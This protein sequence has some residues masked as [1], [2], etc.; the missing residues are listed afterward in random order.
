MEKRFNMR[1][2]DLL[3]SGEGE[4]RWLTSRYYD[5]LE[6]RRGHH[7]A[8]KEA[9][10]LTHIL[11]K[12]EERIRTKSWSAS[13][14]GECIRKQQ[15]VYL[16][17]PKMRLDTKSLNIFSNGDYV[18]MRHQVAGLSRGYLKDVEVPV[19]ISQYN[20]RGTVDGICSDGA[21]AEFK[22][23]NSY[24]FGNLMAP[25]PKHVKQVHAYMQ[26]LGESTARIL[27]ECKNT[28]NIK[29]YEV[30]FDP[31][32]AETNMAEWRLAQAVINQKGLEPPLP[33]DAQECRWCPFKT[34]CH[35]MTYEKAVE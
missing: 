17:V 33:S 10:I 24:G 23:I 34:V 27:Y 22:S 9:D 25:N 3:V 13:S 11:T 35:Q 5:W 20:V 32:I 15:F 12:N 8:E 29:E 2:A 16:G 18:H 21:V 19:E 4:S 6:G 14:A 7:D 26:A 1:F 30:T 28:Q 31:V